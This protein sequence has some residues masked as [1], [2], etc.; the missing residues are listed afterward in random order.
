MKKKIDYLMKV[1]QFINSDLW[2]EYFSDAVL[3]GDFNGITAIF[4][5]SISFAAI[6]F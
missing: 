5:S 6:D 3:D 1:R 2:Y 4:I